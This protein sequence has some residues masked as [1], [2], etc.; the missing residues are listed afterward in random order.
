MS[1]PHMCSFGPAR[2]AHLDAFLS[3][4]VGCM[5]W[6]KGLYVGKSRAKTQPHHTIIPHDLIAL[7][8]NGILTTE[9]S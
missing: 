6:R 5:E 3:I 2:R 8:S 4:R 7:K 1:R 9:F